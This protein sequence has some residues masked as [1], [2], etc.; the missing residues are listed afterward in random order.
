[1]LKI[2]IQFVAVAEH[3]HALASLVKVSNNVVFQVAPL[4]Q[5]IYVF[6]QPHG[7]PAKCDGWIIL[8]MEP[9]QALCLQAASFQSM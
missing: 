5:G 6:S 4:C 2:T 3:F 7:L 8:Y 1:M 9:G